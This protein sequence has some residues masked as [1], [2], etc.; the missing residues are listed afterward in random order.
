MA[1]LFRLSSSSDTVMFPMYQ[2]IQRMRLRKISSGPE[3]TKKSQK[4]KGAAI[5][6]KKITRPTMSI[7]TA[8]ERKKVVNLLFSMARGRVRSG[9]QVDF[10]W[11]SDSD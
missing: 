11:R 9:G 6:M 3:S 10:V 1:C 5:P 2:N 8:S 7:I 4:L